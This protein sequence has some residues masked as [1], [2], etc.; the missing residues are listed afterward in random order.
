MI[1]SW[2]AA[3]A[4]ILLAFGTTAKAEPYFAVRQGLK[5]VACHVNPTGGGMRNAFGTTWSQRILPAQTVD[6]G[7]FDWT[8]AIA[9]HISLGGN[10]RAGFT[11]VDV[12]HED[13]TSEFNVDEAR[14][15]LLF[16]PIP[17]RLQIYVDELV[18]PGSADN[19]EAWAMLWFGNQSFYLKAGQ[20]YLPFGLRL[21]DDTAYVRQVPGINM[22]TPDRGVELGWETVHW[23]A[24]LAISNGTAGSAET[25][26]G[27]QV[28]AKAE[29]VASAWRAGLSGSF[30]NTAAGDRTLGGVFAGL[31]TGPVAWLAEADY[32][33][34]DSVQESGRDSWVGLLEANWSFAPGQNLKFTAE[35]FEPDVDIDQDEQNR[36]SIVWEYVPMQ[37]VQV[38]AGVR[39]YDGIPQND[40]QNR[41]LAFLQLNAYF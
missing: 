10:L 36:W 16:E 19:R 38:R 3:L 1:R 21:E 37:F 6:T 30:N 13:S 26:N 4:L 23:S 32:V 7:G 41:A 31:R 35:Y 22:T 20:F 11:Y 12:P 17:Q 39:S 33:T 25:D 5:C 24:Q 28:T 34:D 8:G 15:Y 9:D 2:T 14:V 40:L 18:A 29:Y 27:K